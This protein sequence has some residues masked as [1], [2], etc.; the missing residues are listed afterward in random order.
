[1]VGA[2]LSTLPFVANF[3]L[4]LPFAGFLSVLFY[5]RWTHGLELRP[6]AG[7]KLGALTGLFSFLGSL[8]YAILNTLAFHGQNAIREAMLQVLRLQQQRATDP[9]ARQVIEY[10]MTPQ[11]MIFMM[12]FSVVLVGVFFVLL[13]GA[14]AAFSTF[15]LRRKGPPQQ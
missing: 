1:V 13:S 8:L 6:G 3:I 15:L 5:R 11:G 14:G 2:V 7:F 10:F 4:A 12:A 9:Q